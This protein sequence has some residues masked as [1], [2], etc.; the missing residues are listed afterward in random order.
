MSTI[1]P[2]YPAPSGSESFTNVRQ[3]KWAMTG[4]DTGVAVMNGNFGDKTISVIGG[5]WTGPTT[6]LVEGSN[7]G[8]NFITLTDP[9]GNAISKTADFIETIE[10]NPLYIRVRSSGGTTNALPVILVCRY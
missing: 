9:Q 8:T 2:T 6:L 7:D 4:A 1:T 3:Y 10:E 5:V